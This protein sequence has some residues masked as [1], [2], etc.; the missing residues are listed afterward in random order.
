MSVPTPC[1]KVPSFP[2]ERACLVLQVA[3]TSE[4]I[5]DTGAHGCSLREVFRRLRER[6][7]ELPYTPQV[8]QRLRRI[9]EPHALGRPAM[10]LCRLPSIA[11]IL[12]VVGEQ[13][14]ALAELPRVDLLDCTRG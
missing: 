3:H 14:R 13:R 11:R 9:V 12:P 1:R 2:E 5:H 8:Q 4:V 6:V 10:P 7:Q